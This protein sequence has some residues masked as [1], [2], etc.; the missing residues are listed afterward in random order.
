MAGPTMAPHP[1]TAPRRAT[2]PDRIAKAMRP[3]VADVCLP[4]P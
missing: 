1:G 2:V 3:D 4:I